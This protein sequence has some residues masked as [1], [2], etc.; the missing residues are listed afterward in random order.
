MVTDQLIKDFEVLCER[1][2][3]E[4]RADKEKGRALLVQAGIL[5]KKG[6]LRKPYRNLRL[7]KPE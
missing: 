7:P 5:T 6:N 2:K 1:L 3:K 4:I